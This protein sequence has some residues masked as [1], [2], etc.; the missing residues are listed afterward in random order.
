MSFDQNSHS[1]YYFV[2]SEEGIWNS[3][4]D[5]ENLG[6]RPRHKEGY[7]PVSPVDS[8][9]DL[10]TDKQLGYVVF[11]SPMPLLE[12]PGIAF[13]VQSP[14]SDTLALRGHTEAFL[15]QARERLEALS[16][17]EFARF[18]PFQLWKIYSHLLQFLQPNPDHQKKRFLQADFS[19]HSYDHRKS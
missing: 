1:G 13:V 2:D 9:Q 5:G 11:A 18:R 10:R 3:G 16:D 14:G 19:N 7:F 8:Y 15:G 6:S 17:E 12:L 4:K